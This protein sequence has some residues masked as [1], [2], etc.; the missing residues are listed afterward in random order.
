MNS[1][2]SLGL[3]EAY[4]KVEQLGDRLSEITRLIDW[5]AF[6]PQLEDMYNNKTEKGGRPNFD[7]ILMLKVLLL[8]QW[9]SLSDMEA[10]KQIAD[11]ISF[12]KFLSF[13]DSIPDSRTIWLFR[14]RLKETGK[15][16]AIWE[17]LQRQL[18]AKGLTIKRGSIQDATFIEADPGKSKRLRGENSKT[19]RSRDG[20]WAKKGDE[21]HFGYKLHSKVDI[22][23]G[24]IRDIETTTAS[25]HD[26]QVDLSVEGE[27]ILRDKG[28][29][30]VPAKGIDFTMKRATAERPLGDIDKLRNRLIT[31]LRSPGER[32]F[33]VIK[34]VFRVAH[35]MVT[36]VQRVRIKM[37]FSSFAFNLYQLCTLKNAGII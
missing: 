10:E 6:R 31:K 36:T 3:R 29:F 25:L 27:A 4:R 20:T 2:T 18:D 30:G 32:P 35:V 9:Y 17:E 37:M 22:D 24:L 7:V 13:P 14:E 1:F 33:A 8:Q 11:R 12:M 15:D 28:Y 26:S 23:Y 19:R 34:R 5:G 16:K 21:L